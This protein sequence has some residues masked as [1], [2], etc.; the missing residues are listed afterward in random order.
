MDHLNGTL[1]RYPWG[2]TDAIPALLGIPADGGPI[3]EYWL[4][5]HPLSPSHLGDIAL[6][7]LLRSDPD[8]LG[9][10]SV[11]TFGPT[12]PFLM[13]VLSARHALS[14]Q[15][16]PSR[17]QA[18]AGYLAEEERGIARTAS[19]RTYRDDWPKPEIMIA[20]SEF[21][22]LLGFRDPRVTLRLFSKLGAGP[23][24]ERLLTPLDARGGVAAMQEV[25]LDVLSISEDRHSIVSDVLRAAHDHAADSGDIGDF[26]RTAIEL[27]ADFGEDSGIIAA[28]LMNRVV[29]APG[30]AV[31][32]PTG[33]MHAHLHGTGIEVMGSSD[34]VLRGGLTR[35]HIAVDELVS[36]VDFAW[37]TPFIL[38][39]T[40]T[41]P[42]VVSYPTECREFDV[43]RLDVAPDNPVTLPADGSARIALVTEG[44]A[45][46][47]RGGTHLGGSRGAS[48]FFAAHDTEIEVRGDAQ[49]FVSAPGLI[50]VG[51]R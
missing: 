15:A 13:K 41:A 42:G 37:M 40:E 51:S 27:E 11:S 28:L 1:M 38:G 2:T 4:G 39:G 12:L 29:L 17:E 44:Q 9:E 49:V 45:A 50:R 24:L 18:E 25:F 34:N 10:A 46:F 19:E 8:R 43:W 6:N 48:L 7:D 14:L 31:Y 3:A 20:L 26:A 35:K 32:V 22:T 23:D 36:V 30:E 47:H 5:A 33:S 21:H 16:H